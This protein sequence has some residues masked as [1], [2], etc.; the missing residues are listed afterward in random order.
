MTTLSYDIRTTVILLWEFVTL[1]LMK[2][3]CSSRKYSACC[4]SCCPQTH[5]TGYILMCCMSGKFFFPVD[6][7]KFLQAASV[8]SLSSAFPSTRQWDRHHAGSPRTSAA[9]DR[10]EKLRLDVQ[11]LYL[12]H[13]Q[14]D[15]YSTRQRSLFFSLFITRCFSPSSP[16]HGFPSPQTM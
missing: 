14:T 12:N 7:Q 9:E 16:P 15:T 3:Y 11:T 10:R 6:N 5:Y 1:W 8:R 13:M 2:G 4:I